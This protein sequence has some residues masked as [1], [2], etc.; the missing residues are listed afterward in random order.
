MSAVDGDRLGAVTGHRRGVDA[1]ATGRRSKTGNRR[2]NS[3]RIAVKKGDLLAIL[4]TRPF[5]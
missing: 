3:S 2:A 5:E 4:D 1:D